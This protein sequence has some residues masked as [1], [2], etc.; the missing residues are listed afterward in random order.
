MDEILHL[1]RASP[2]LMLGFEGGSLCK[3]ASALPLCAL[4][5]LRG[6]GAGFRPSTVSESLVLQPP[7][8]YFAHYCVALLRRGL[9]QKVSFCSRPGSISHILAW[10]CCAAAPC[11][12][13]AAPAF[14]DGRRM[15]FRGQF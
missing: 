14:R 13:S 7:W 2:T 6:A 3:P 4:M 9:S 10:P 12:K 5:A 8:V 15:S 1:A 11:R